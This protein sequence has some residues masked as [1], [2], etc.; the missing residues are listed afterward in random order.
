MSATSAQLVYDL[1]KGRRAT[2]YISGGAGALFY[3]DETNT[4][5]VRRTEV[6]SLVPAPG[7]AEVSRYEHEARLFWTDFA[8]GVRIYTAYGISVV[9]EVRLSGGLGSGVHDFAA[10]AVVKILYRF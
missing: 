5:P 7:A 4:A 1:M 3:H 6:G 2:P 9:P 10:S 8:F